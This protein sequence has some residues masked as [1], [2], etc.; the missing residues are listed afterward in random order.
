MNDGY[1]AKW[2]VHDKTP[3]EIVSKV[4]QLSHMLVHLLY[5][6]GYTSADSILSF[7]L[8]GDID[9]DPY[10]M[11]HMR[12]SVDL[13]H[14]HVEKNSTIAVYGDFDCDG[15]TSSALL[16]SVLRERFS[17]EPIVVVPTRR[18]GHGLADFRIEEL[19]D[20]GVGL[21]ITVDCG[22]TSIREVDHIHRL[23]MDVIVT[24]HHEPGTTL[25]SCLIVNPSLPESTYPYK[26]LAGV[27]V[28]Y[29]LGQALMGSR[30]A[31]SFV[32]DLAAL[33]TVADVVPLRDENRSIVVRGLQ[34]IKSRDRLGLH[35]L[36]KSSG[37]DIKRLDS[38]SLSFYVAPKIN[39][40]N[41]MADPI[42][43]YNLLMT[44]DEPEARALSKELGLLNKSRQSLL[45]EHFARVASSLDKEQFEQDV[46][47]GKRAPILI[48]EGDWPPGISGLIA[49]RLSERY[50]VPTICAAENE[51]GEISASARS[52]PGVNIISIIDECTP[53]FKKFGGHTGAA[54]FICKTRSQFDD[55]YR[56]IE[57]SARRV[58]DSTSAVPLM[59]VD[60]EIDL[61]QITSFACQQI[62]KL[63]PYG[64]DFPE[65][66]FLAR[67]IRLVDRKMM[68]DGKHMSATATRGWKR[69]RAVFFSHDLEIEMTDEDQQ[70][71]LV[72]NLSMNNWGRTPEAQIMI[73]D[74]RLTEAF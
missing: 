16:Y 19:K 65:P 64:Q 68:S 42:T 60:A 52:T 11:P 74:W 34:K 58:I 26:M 28:T 45:E 49:S 21:I 56:C 37:I 13:I 40:A 32:D 20:Q 22:V 31:M 69:V 72:F 23:G 7:L 51:W 12:E 18:E 10:L 55:A 57:E 4:G 27:G 63:G 67:G 25:P 53:H 17:I 61:S 43:A 8:D 9:H 33:G 5:V 41:R 6:R 66:L 24:D 59:N 36:L 39:S 62:E 48:V 73:R 30:G 70:F 54:G 3:V 15:I 71:D 38:G 50:G 44:K 46:L 14:K 35:H 47:S 29:K 2:N 1:R